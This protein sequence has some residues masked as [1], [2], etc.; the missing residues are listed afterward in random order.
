[1]EKTVNQKFRW[2]VIGTGVI[3]NIV[4]AQIVKS[5]RHCV[6][7][8]YS[9]T[10]VKAQKFAKRF[11]ARYYDSAAAMLNDNNIDAVYIATP[12]SSHYDYIKQC[13]E[14]GKPVLAE[15]AFTVNAQQAAAVARIARDKRVLLCEAMWTRFL[16]VVKQTAEAVNSGAIGSVRAF[17][18]A[19]STPL[20]LARPFLTDRIDKPEYAGGALLDIGVYPVSFAQ[21]LLGTPESVSCCQV[22]KNGV[23]YQDEITLTYRDCKCDLKCSFDKIFSSTGIIFGES[24]KIVIPNFS[25]PKRAFVYGADG[26]RQAVIKGDKSYVFEFDA[27]SQAVKQ[28]KAECA[29]MPLDDTVAVMRILDE[30]RAQNNFKYPDAIEQA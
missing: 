17:S 9:R 25:R 4:C 18:A 30:C 23:D 28:G 13:I 22:I 5:G 16:P 8:V 15:K 26:K 11:G 27:F 6:T 10:A 14:G 1:M 7:A 29:E 20:K 19:F 12:H 24:G 21:M 2:A 3:A